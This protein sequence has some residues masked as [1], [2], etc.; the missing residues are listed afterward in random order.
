MANVTLSPLGYNDNLTALININGANHW[1]NVNASVG[2]LAATGEC[3]IDRKKTPRPGIGQMEHWINS[4]SV[5]GTIVSID[6]TGHGSYNFPPTGTYT[7]SANYSEIY[8]VVAHSN[9]QTPSET[10]TIQSSSGWSG[11]GG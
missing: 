1:F 3:S 6:G 10:A 5:N 2:P 8:S 11:T 4:F 9:G 7:V